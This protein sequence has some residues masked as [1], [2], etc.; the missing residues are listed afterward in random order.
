MVP[1]QQDAV[2]NGPGLPAWCDEAL[3]THGDAFAK[4]ASEA[5]A[6]TWPEEGVPKCQLSVLLEV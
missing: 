3:P 2:E 5:S 4:F 1:L 6:E